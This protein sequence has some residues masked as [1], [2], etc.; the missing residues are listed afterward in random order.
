[1]LSLINFLGLYSCNHSESFAFEK[2][3]FTTDT[4]LDCKNVDCASLEIN[5]LKIVDD[6]P[7]ATTI[8]KEIENAAC[9]ILNI[10]KN[11]SAPNLKEAIY[12]FNDSYQSISEEFPEEIIP[13]EATIDCELSFQS[14]TLISIA[15]DFYVY[16]GGEH[17]YAGVSHINMNPKTGKQIS[18]TSL[19][20]NYN[21]FEH[22]V[23]QI[24]RA[25]HKI[26][27]GKSINSTG[28]F[29]KNDKF[30]LPESIGFTDKEVILH[31]NIYEII[32]S[33]EKG[34]IELRLDKKE[35]ASF[36]T[37]TIL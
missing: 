13:Y 2:Q 30:N 18:N 26:P 19:F 25:Q 16:T 34:T 24:F 8:N 29:F 9:S 1:M 21:E 14:T 10:D 12:R 11:S 32:S 23:E 15:M 7:I 6:S 27:E 33:E 31:Y 35:V 28:F 5:L 4:F 22:Y 36:F 37:F 20:K 3:N 17:G